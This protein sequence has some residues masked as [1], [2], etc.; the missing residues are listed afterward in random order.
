MGSSHNSSGW[1]LTP[2][3]SLD[4]GNEVFGGLKINP[5]IGAER[6]DQLLLGSPS[7]DGNDLET[8]GLG[9]LD[10]KVTET[11]TSTGKGNPI[12]DLCVGNLESLIRCDTSTED[13]GS[14]SRIKGRGMGV[15]W[16][17]KE[18]TYSAKVPST[19]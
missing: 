11:A 14:T 6:L 5:S 9:V 7:V 13:R 4:V 2:S 17:T 19:V 1:A 8:H 3:G 16:L 18:T 10:S 15:T 12:T